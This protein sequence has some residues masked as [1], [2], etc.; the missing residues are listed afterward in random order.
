MSD[1]A[2]IGGYASALFS[3][4]RAEGH[5]SEVEDEM[6]RFARALE[7]SDELRSTLSDSLIPPAKRQAIVED[8]L[9]DK[10]TTTTKSFVSMLVAAGR[11]RD[12]GGISD[13][14]VRRTASDKSQTVTEIRSAVALSD[15]Q[16]ARLEA[17]LSQ[18]TGKSVAVKVIVDPSLRGGVVAQVGDVVIDGSIS[19]RLA[20]LK[21]RL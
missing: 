2:R 4:A 13:Q 16:R 15:D 19:T 18:A 7:S 14:L 12:I 21:S 1:D 3:I 5:L 10:T 20:Q 9:G 11:T 6:F 17:A 8:L